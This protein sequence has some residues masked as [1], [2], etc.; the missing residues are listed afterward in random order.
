[1][2]FHCHKLCH[3][4]Q[5]KLVQTVL[6]FASCQP[7]DPSPDLQSSPSN[8][9]PRKV[10]RKHASL[11][12][13]FVTQLIQF[14]WSFMTKWRKL[15][16]GMLSDASQAKQ[17]IDYQR[18]AQLLWQI[19]QK[20]YIYRLSGKKKN[21]AKNAVFIDRRTLT[22]G[23]PPRPFPVSNADESMN[24]LLKNVFNFGPDLSF[25]KSTGESNRIEVDLR[26][27]YFSIRTAFK[28]VLHYIASKHL[29]TKLVNTTSPYAVT[30]YALNVLK[31]EKNYCDHVNSYAK[32][33]GQPGSIE[34]THGKDEK[35][36]V[37]ARCLESFAKFV[38]TSHFQPH[39]VVI[40]SA[41]P[42]IFLEAIKIQ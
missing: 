29:S 3:H 22:F 5:K 14:L 35:L 39:V 28:A 2:G 40:D 20:G 41:H 27:N 36:Y 33:E 15:E 11:T 10:P 38:A 1:M 19:V 25:D 34:F 42:P 32:V 21:G 6:V 30:F 23:S 12:D 17:T 7:K 26:L 31:G 13:I 8:S 4:N 9:P 37:S 18:T 24:W 16:N